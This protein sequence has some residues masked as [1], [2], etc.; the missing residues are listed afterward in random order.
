[1]LPRGWPAPGGKEK[2]NPKI[3]LK[4]LDKLLIE[5]FYKLNSSSELELR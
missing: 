5:G 1:V 2:R 4:S 3:E